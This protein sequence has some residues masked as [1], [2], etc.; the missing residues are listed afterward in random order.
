M[1]QIIKFFFSFLPTS[2]NMDVPEP[3]FNHLCEDHVLGNWRAMSCRVPEWWGRI[4]M[5]D[6]CVLLSLSYSHFLLSYNS[7]QLRAEEIFIHMVVRQ[8]MTSLQGQ[9]LSKCHIHTMLPSARRPQSLT[10]TTFSL[11]S[12]LLCFLQ[13]SWTL[14]CWGN[15]EAPFRNRSQKVQIS[16]LLKIPQGIKN[17]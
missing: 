1:S 16:G 3:S 7:I 12:S 14:T 8:D 9:P 17:E 15:H 10:V 6:H 4:R 13:L 2:S 11:V 5:P